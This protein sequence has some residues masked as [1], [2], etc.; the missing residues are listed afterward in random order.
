GGIPQKGL[1]A[2]SVPG[3]VACWG[4]ALERYGSKP[5]GSLLQTAI[6]Y[7][8]DGVPVTSK[9]YRMLSNDSSVYEQFPESARVFAPDGRV[10]EIGETLRQPGLARSLERLAAD[11]WEDFYRGA[12]AKE[13]VEYSRSHDG[14]FTL[15]DFANHQTEAASPISINYRGFT[16][17][18]QP[19]VS[20]GIIVLLAL[21]ILQ[22]FDI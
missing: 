1:W 16:V 18:E 14:L 5:L 21:N 7:A 8:R 4:T 19:P 20:Q 12:L 10:P 22:Q 3:T 9:L 11:G 17:F 15:E 13:L 6:D 2:S